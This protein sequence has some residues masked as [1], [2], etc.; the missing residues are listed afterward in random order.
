MQYKSP[1]SYEPEENESIE[2]HSLIAVQQN[3]SFTLAQ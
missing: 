2:K 1:F 3:V